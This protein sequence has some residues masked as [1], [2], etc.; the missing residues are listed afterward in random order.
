MYK[1]V[2]IDERHGGK[3]C[4]RIE[5]E[6]LSSGSSSASDFYFLFWN[7]KS[8][9]FLKNLILTLL[10]P[11]HFTQNFWPSFNLKKNHYTSQ[12]FKLFI[13]T[14]RRW[15]RWL[16]WSFP[17]L[18]FKSLYGFAWS[19]WCVIKISRI[20]TTFIAWAQS[21]ERIYNFSWIILLEW[22][23]PLLAL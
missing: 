9:W 7:N 10:I 15:T 12:I 18:T 3:K 6:V 1:C 21:T 11:N 19:S 22:L 2:I 5:L 14:L 4:K 13:F 23:P 17:E 8:C 16:L 20:T